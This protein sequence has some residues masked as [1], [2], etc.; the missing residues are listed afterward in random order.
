MR[1]SYRF[2]INNGQSL[3]GGDLAEARVGANEMVEHTAGAGHLPAE[4][5][6]VEVHDPSCNSTTIARNR[7]SAANRKRAD[8]LLLGLRTHRDWQESAWRVVDGIASGI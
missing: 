3:I 5:A 2:R 6:P 8:G 4:G 7:R 1:G